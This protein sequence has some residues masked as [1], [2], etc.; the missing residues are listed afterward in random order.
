MATSGDFFMATSGD[1][2]MAPDMVAT[3]F[4]DHAVPRAEC[5]PC[6]AGVIKGAD[7][8]FVIVGM[9]VKQHP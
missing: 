4:V 1:F 3:M 7:D 2:F 6:A 9:L 8:I 5:R